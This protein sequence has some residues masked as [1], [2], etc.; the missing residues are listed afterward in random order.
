MMDDC[1]P[2]SQ[3]FA[4]IALCQQQALFSLGCVNTDGSLKL[5]FFQII[6][7][8]QWKQRQGSAFNL[9]VLMVAA[10]PQ[11]GPIHL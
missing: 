5:M 6:V 8:A 9:S 4:V 3:P 1:V 2:D 11:K 7:V 10:R